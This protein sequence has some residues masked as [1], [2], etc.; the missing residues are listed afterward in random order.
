MW[1]VTQ[2]DPKLHCDHALV[3]RRVIT[4][5][6]ERA[7]A[8]LVKGEAIVGVVEANQ[9]PPDARR[10][11]VGD[12]VILPGLVD[13]HVHVNEPGRT[14]WEGFA[15]ATRAAAAGGVT[16][17]VD[18]PLNSS[19]VTTTRDALLRKL[20]AAAGQGVV[21]CAFWGGLVPGNLK[22]LGELLDAGACGVKAFLCHSGIDDFPAAGEAELRAALPILAERG[23]PLLV[24]A[25]LATAETTPAGDPRRYATYLESRP[26][27][28]EQA[29]VALL[30]RLCR[31]L[32]AAVHVV[33]LSAAAAVPL[34][35]EARR[36]G[37]PLSAETCPHY[38]ALAAEE[39][40]D[41]R[42]EFKCAPPVREESNRAALWDALADG[43]I[44]LVVSDHS[45]CPPLL[46]RPDGG[47]FM[48]AW[49]GIASLQLA[50][51]VVWS[52]A[53]RRGVGI[54][55]LA[56]WMA[57]APARLSGLGA[58][59]GRIA[60]ACDADLVVF[61]PDATF[62]VAA[63]AIEHRHKLTPYLGRR[64]HGVVRQSWVRGR[65]VF[66]AGAFEGSPRG[67]LVNGSD[68]RR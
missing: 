23:K 41:G 50:L 68:G 25:E 37:L 35:A 22:E 61:D 26:P 17:I 48:A 11:D 13:S 67:A 5:E 39:V 40:A 12:A 54:E 43:T 30:L 33:H 10:E 29:A 44:E 34:V 62:E 63:R 36:E 24:H 20:D 7:G 53:R 60:P 42:T 2:P 58:R 46:K 51:P 28:W 47:D 16:T 14:D 27:S 59:K 32:R 55:R 64:L 15:S 45:P 56:E 49:G 57:A 18:M 31:E 3:S 66:S 52:E 6:G 8:V 1:A 19:P 9:V 21:D 65:R 38:L 4:P